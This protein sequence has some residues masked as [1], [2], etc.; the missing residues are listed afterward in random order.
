MGE[1]GFE[2]SAVGAAPAH[3][4][5]NLKVHPALSNERVPDLTGQAG[6]PYRST[7]EG[8]DWEALPMRLY[9]R[10]T[11]WG[12]WSPWQFDLDQDREHWERFS[13]GDREGI[14]ALTAE[15]LA[16]EET[17]TLDIL[18]L[19]EAIQAVGSSEETLFLGTFVS[20]ET[21]HTT[22]FRHYF[23]RAVPGDPKPEALTPSYR[24]VFSKAL[25]AAM[26]GLSP[27]ASPEDLVRAAAT[28]NLFVEGVLAETGYW[29]YART[30]EE[31]NLLPG[32][33]EALVHIQ[34]DESRHIAYGVFLLSRLVAEDP[35]L[36]DVVEATMDDLFEHLPG[37]VHETAEFYG[38]TRFAP[39]PA[40]VI[41]YASGQLQKRLATV[42]RARGWSPS[43][44]DEE[45]GELLEDVEVRAG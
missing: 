12:T 22:F 44:I 20:D 14:A 10:W 41:D 25:P 38:E 13:E 26:E 8:L 5:R 42:E 39:D 17:V 21:K 27:D 23:D 40:E 34:R 18:P 28:Y 45:V 30:L 2:L 1:R 37:I 36:W 32:L 6:R 31:D 4:P 3:R 15:F 7:D 33:R 29:S 43:A 24:E 11:R 9:R 35:D 19:V 16:G